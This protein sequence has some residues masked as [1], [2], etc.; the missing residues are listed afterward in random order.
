MPT[1]APPS[2]P[3]TQSPPATKP[4]EGDRVEQMS[5]MRKKIAEHM[6]QSRRTSAHV[7]TVYEIDLTRIAKLRLFRVPEL[8]SASFVL[9]L[10][11]VM[12]TFLVR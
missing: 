10:L 9:A 1:P 6:V 12:S 8:L 4:A 11:A 2:T 7:T 5:V 3:G